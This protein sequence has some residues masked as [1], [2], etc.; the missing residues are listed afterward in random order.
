VP[1]RPNIGRTVQETRPAAIWDFSPWHGSTMRRPRAF[2]VAPVAALLL[3]ISACADDSTSAA[4]Q[5]SPVPPGAVVFHQVKHVVLEAV[6]PQAFETITVLAHVCA[7]GS[8]GCPDGSEDR[9]PLATQHLMPGQLFM[10]HP[11]VYLQP[12]D[13]CLADDTVCFVSVAHC[14]FSSRSDQVAAGLCFPAPNNT[15]AAADPW[16]TGQT[17]TCLSKKAIHSYH[18]DHACLLEGASS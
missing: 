9:I 17:P 11:E 6:S 13:S 15:N 4:Q 7:A 12:P 5:A 14:E 1:D 10:S 16:R 2:A 18:I 3:I 8:R